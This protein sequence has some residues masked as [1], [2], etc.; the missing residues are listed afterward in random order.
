MDVGATKP[1]PAVASRTEEHDTEDRIEG[2]PGLQERVTASL[3][4]SDAAFLPTAPPVAQ[5]DAHAVPARESSAMDARDSEST[6]EPM[7]QSALP[8][9]VASALAHLQHLADALVNTGVARPFPTGANGADEPGIEDRIEGGLR[10]LEGYCLDASTDSS[11]VAQVPATVLESQIGQLRMQL[12]GLM[13]P[14]PLLATMRPAGDIKPAGAGARGEAIASGSERPA[15]GNLSRQQAQRVPDAG[16]PGD[17]EATMN[18]LP[19]IVVR[20]V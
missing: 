7:P 14:P 13:S 10:F 5:Q 12:Q 9:E 3:R 20:S 8:A 17:T 6:A 18:T 15:R 2:G 19:L 4:D 1:P 11:A 16:S